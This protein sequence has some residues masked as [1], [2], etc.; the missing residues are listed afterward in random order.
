MDEKIKIIVFNIMDDEYGL[1]I[2]YIQEI[3]KM[4][5]ITY[6]PQA[7]DFVKGVIKIR[8]RV[9]PLI[10]FRKRMGL[11]FKEYGDYTKII[12]VNLESHIIGIVVDM[13]S[14]LLTIPQGNVDHPDSVLASVDFLKGVG[15][16][17]GRM[18]LIVDMDKVLSLDDKKDL[19]KIQ[20]CENG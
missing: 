18:V 3:R 14:E 20:G 7:P 16:I 17:P 11:P 13:V 19:S 8:G 15:N 10:D 5:R 6:I 12:I 4:R 2:E 1:E 9:I